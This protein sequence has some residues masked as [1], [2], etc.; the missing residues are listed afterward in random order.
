MPGV[1]RRLLA[2]LAAV[3]VLLGAALTTGAGAAP[4]GAAAPAQG[5]PPSTPFTTPNTD[6]CPY[7]ST[8]PAP[9]DASEVPAPGTAA[10][11]PLPRPTDPV[12][13]GAL[14]G[15]G[16]VQAA[17]SPAVPEGISAAAWVVADL[18]TGE[19]LAAK[20][21]HGRHRP[22]STLK[23]LTSLLVL[24]TLPLDRVVTGTQADADVEG[25]GVG[26]GPGGQYTVRQLLTGLL[27]NSGNDA[28]HALAVALGGVDETV[29]AMNALAASV[30]ALDT[31]A[32]T[33]SGLDAPGESTSAY[34]LAV[35][36]GLAIA[37]PT[38]A[39]LTA[40]PRAQFPG[41]A[42]KPAFEID[43][44]DA[45]LRNYPGAL[46]GKP[47]YTDDARQT[48]VGAA[49]RGGRRL[50]VALVHGERT[51][52]QPW[53]Q[54]AALLD[55]GFALPP[56]SGIGRLVTAA[57]AVT[58][59]DP[60]STAAVPGVAAGRS[61]PVGAAAPAPRSATGV[62]GTAAL[63]LGAALVVVVLLVGIDAVRR[64][65]RTG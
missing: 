55:H 40:T 5:P 61:G 24:R 36:F 18:D 44:D 29:T 16:V 41:Y 49:E 47:G 33:P 14:G 4:A 10:P 54:A 48:F 3:A 53:Q 45:L 19:V 34:D 38:F 26:V 43:N 22:A 32:A 7:A 39:Q 9:V 56:G 57:P 21:P 63:A 37:D 2:L 1:H 50:V 12:G 28:A 64:R 52:L 23:V 30:G 46:G 11:A 60:A 27:L 62:L 13:G 6:A 35:F 42:D 17:G 31:R 8:P 25:S 15:C 58:A 51:P 59:P 65:R 20:D